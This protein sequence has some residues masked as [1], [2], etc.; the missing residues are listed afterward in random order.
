MP[1]KEGDLFDVQLTEPSGESPSTSQ[2]RIAPPS[3]SQIP[4][5]QI[6]SKQMVVL[7]H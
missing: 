4:D 6:K 3:L 2:Q 5:P 7:S 1:I